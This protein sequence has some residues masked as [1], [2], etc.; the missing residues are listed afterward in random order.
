M[1]TNTRFRLGVAPLNERFALESP[2][3][4]F[5]GAVAVHLRTLFC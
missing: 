3:R 2:L 1:G 4:P 5:I